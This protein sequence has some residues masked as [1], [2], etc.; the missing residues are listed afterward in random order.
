MMELHWSATAEQSLHIASL[1][2][3]CRPDAVAS[4]K[5]WLATQTG[6]SVPA[7]S[8]QGKLVLLV[9]TEQEQ[10]ILDLLEHLG[11]CAGVAHAALVYHEIIA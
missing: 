4:L 5:Q 6:V 1:A 3:Y 10:Q 9:E 2:V 7:E 8:E 11:Q